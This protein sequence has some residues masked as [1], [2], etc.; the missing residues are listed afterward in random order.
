MFSMKKVLL[1]I[2]IIILVLPA[3]AKKLAD[4]PELSRPTWLTSHGDR[5]YAVEGTT[6]FIYSFKDYTFIKKFGRAGEG[7]KEIKLPQ[8]GDGV[9]LFHWGDKLIVGSAGKISF[10]T[11]DGDFIKEM[12]VRGAANLVMHQPLGDKFA[13]LGVVIDGKSQSVFMT[14]NLYDKDLNKEKEL[15]R[16]PYM[17]KSRLMFPMAL[18]LFY[19][20]D[21]HIVV[22][23]G[24][25]QAV[26]IFDGS[27]KKIAYAGREYKPLNIT[28]T[29][30][31]RVFTFFKTNPATKQNFELIKG[32]VQFK[33]TFP[34]VQLIY[35]AD[36]TIYI[37]TYLEKEGKHEFLSFDFKGKFLKR[38]FL[39]IG[40]QDS[41]RPA[42]SFFRNNKLYQAVENIDTETIELH[43]LE[44]K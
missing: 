31:D 12:S 14:L 34:G 17:Q 21:D 38:F 13:G 28:D 41:L 32:L 5:M 25:K 36:H 40:F 33:D 16:F 30:K 29:Y 44:A 11:R 10:F 26:H 23:D 35:T 22:A 39:P 6:I 18:P 1:V 4:L 42:P 37:L 43:V 9:L 8:G 15:L 3:A 20:L 19:I 24:E 7:P 27:G 2:F